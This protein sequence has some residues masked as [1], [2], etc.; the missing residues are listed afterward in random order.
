[1]LGSP[2]TGLGNLQGAAA[3]IKGPDFCVGV[4]VGNV[5]RSHSRATAGIQNA[6]LAP[7]RMGS[8]TKG[9]GLGPTPAPIPPWRGNSADGLRGER[10]ELVE[11][12]HLVE[13][14]FGAAG[15]GLHGLSVGFG[16]VASKTIVTKK[17]G[18][19]APL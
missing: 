15:V 7:T 4:L 9:M 16:P 1:V 10:V 14:L 2:T 17:T 13:H 12:P 8:R 18:F 3:Q 5:F 11:L 6:H 19:Q